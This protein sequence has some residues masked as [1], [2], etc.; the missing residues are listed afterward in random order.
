MGGPVVTHIWD[1]NT[2]LDGGDGITFTNPLNWDTNVVPDANDIAIFRTDD[3]GIVNVGT[4]YVGEVRFDGAGSYTLQGG[5]LSSNKIDQQ[6][7]ASGINTISAQLSSIVIT[8]IVSASQLNLTNT[9]NSS[10]VLGGT[11]TIGTGGKIVTSTSSAANTGLGL[12]KC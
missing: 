9:A 6:A 4:I 3:P 7:T 2:D 5:T 12:A 11:W 1:G 8:G 10:T